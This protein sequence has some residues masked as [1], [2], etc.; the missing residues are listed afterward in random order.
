MS[1][2]SLYFFQLESVSYRIRF[3]KKV[4][5]GRSPLG[6][7][8]LKYGL[9]TDSY[10]L[11]SIFYRRFP[12]YIHVLRCTLCVSIVA[13]NGF[14]SICVRTAVQQNTYNII[15][16]TAFTKIH[17]FNVKYLDS[18]QIV[19]KQFVYRYIYTL[20]IFYI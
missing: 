17:T 6:E 5:R 20:P 10:S 3:E 16:N 1:D 19:F 15:N 7:G 8:G 4:N 18:W 12:K 11:G 13:T 2:I 14:E 9:N